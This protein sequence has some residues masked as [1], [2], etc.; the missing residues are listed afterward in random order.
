MDQ[1]LISL[2]QRS[3]GCSID[4]LAKKIL[5][6]A[7]TV[8]RDSKI[9]YRIKDSQTLEKK[10]ALKR[11]AS[12]FDI[13]DVYGLRILTSSVEKSYKI[14]NAVFRVFPGH[15]DHDFIANPKI[16]LDKPHLKE[17]GLRMLQIVV[18]KN[19]T[20]FEVQIT[21]FEFNDINESYHDQYHR[22]RYSG[23]STT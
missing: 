3:I 17:G 4:D 19:K 10:M 18:Y 15:I 2:Y 1:E 23:S 21:T 22:E 7:K 20:P 13:D 8:S 9:L 11:A 12:V 6:I 16:R 5:G 14:A